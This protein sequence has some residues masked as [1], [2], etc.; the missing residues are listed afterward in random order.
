MGRDEAARLLGVPVD[1]DSH[2][3]R[4]AY[5]MWARVAH[6]DV[7]G[8]PLHFARLTQARRILIRPLPWPATSTGG[9]AVP[10]RAPLSSMVRRPTHLIS[11]VLGAIASVAVAAIPLLGIA[12][13]IGA[14]SAGMASASWSAIATRAILRTGADAGHRIAALAC[15]WLPVAAMQVA[16]SMVLGTQL[17]AALPLL[18]LPFAGVVASVNA[19]AGLW[20]PIGRDDAAGG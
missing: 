7:G 14:L 8:D 15:T 17:I 2:Q 12:P 6:P 20:R 5:R 18:A 13:A 3:V 10:P 9:H 16:L 4:Q 19:G 11:L 1:A